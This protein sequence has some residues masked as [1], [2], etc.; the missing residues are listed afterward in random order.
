MKKN[1]IDIY[2][3]LF[4]ITCYNANSSTNRNGSFTK[5]VEMNMTIDNYQELIQLSVI[6]LGNH[7]LFLEYNWLQKHNLSINQKNSFI[8]LQNCRQWYRRIYVPKEPEENTIEKKETVL[9][10]NLEEEAWRKEEL[11]IRSRSESIEEIE[12]DISKEYK[13]FNDRV[14]NK[15]VFKK[16]PDQS[17]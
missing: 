1:N 16:L 10:V 9:F 11:N 7:N 12:R 17:K 8:S 15:A 13:D 2:K 3:L 5:V 6:N 14:F 4:P